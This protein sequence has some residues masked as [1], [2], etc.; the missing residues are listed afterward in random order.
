MLSA[1]GAFPY[2]L[3]IG[4]GY[5][6]AYFETMSGFTTTGITMFTGLDSMPRSILF[7]RSLTQWV[8][9]LGILTFFLAVSS[10]IL[11]GHLLFGA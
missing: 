8:G 3:G 6:D 2:V 7:W 11:G 10:R 9:G 1:S 4:A 5:L